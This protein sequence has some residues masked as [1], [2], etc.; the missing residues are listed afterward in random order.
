MFL[1]HVA[2]C[3]CSGA[4]DRPPRDRGASEPAAVPRVA[5]ARGARRAQARG[6]VRVRHTVH[7]CRSGLVRASHRA[8][9]LVADEAKDRSSAKSGSRYWH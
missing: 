4:R 6:A 7:R 8:V 9:V 1:L 5:L 2:Y 3:T